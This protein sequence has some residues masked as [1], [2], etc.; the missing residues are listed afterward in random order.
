MI[1]AAEEKNP[2]SRKIHNNREIDEALRAYDSTAGLLIGLEDRL[3]ALGITVSFIRP[4]LDRSHP[5]L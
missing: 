1:S 3:T 5:A 2:V 4:T